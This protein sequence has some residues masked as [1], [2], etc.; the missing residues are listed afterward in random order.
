MICRIVKEHKLNS[1]Q[2]IFIKENKL[3]WKE[4]ND[5]QVLSISDHRQK[6]DALP[7]GGEGEQNRKRHNSGER[8]C[9]E[10]VMASDMTHFP[11]APSVCCAALLLP[12]KVSVCVC[13]SIGDL[14]PN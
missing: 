11:A 10:S 2:T 9:L 5:V 8:G 3:Q 14:C 1:S 12:P 13:V 4:C 7:A 6:T